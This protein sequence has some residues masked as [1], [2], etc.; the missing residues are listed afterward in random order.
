M[1]GEEQ[2]RGGKKQTKSRPLLSV[3][4]LNTVVLTWDQRERDKRGPRSVWTGLEL[5][6]KRRSE[7][8]S[9]CLVLQFAW[10]L[11]CKDSQ[12]SGALPDKKPRPTGRSET[13]FLRLSLARSQR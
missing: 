5:Q 13:H 2:R 1:D 6:T 9:E 8:L 10:L 11:G 4:L 3:A 7:T 12:M